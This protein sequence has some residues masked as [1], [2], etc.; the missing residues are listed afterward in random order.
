MSENQESMSS[1]ASSSTQ[2]RHEP[3][4]NEPG[5]GGRASDGGQE[6]TLTTEAQ[7]VVSDLA[8]KA[9]HSAEQQ[10]AGGKERA[11]QIIGQLAEALRHSG[12]TLSS[13]T[14]MPMVNDY[15][16]RAA[17]QIEG[18]SGYV[19]EKSLT[20]VV[21]DVEQF[22]RREPVLF[23]SGAFLLGLLSGRLLRSSQ[24]SGSASAS[25]GGQ[26]ARTRR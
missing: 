11:V 19:K 26:G 18:L 5:R 3:L 25:N 7:Q 6:R 16:G 10:F 1:A 8:D 15:L 14:N 17:T 9:T 24:P 12:Q 23:T 21:G 22:A 4:G 20:D 2:S 13:S